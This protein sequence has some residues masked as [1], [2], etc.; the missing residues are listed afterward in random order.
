[1][2][3]SVDVLE[4]TRL[5]FS[6]LETLYFS[7]GVAITPR[8]RRTNSRVAI[9]KPKIKFKPNRFKFYVHDRDKSSVSLILYNY[10][11]DGSNYPI[12]ITTIP[13]R[14]IQQRVIVPVTLSMKPLIQVETGPIIKTELV[15][16]RDFTLDRSKL[17]IVDFEPGELSPHIVH[18]DDEETHEE[19]MYP[20]VGSFGQLTPP[21]YI[22]NKWMELFKNCENQELLRELFVDDFLRTKVMTSLREFYQSQ[23]WL[24]ISDAVKCDS[25]KHKTNEAC[26]CNSRAKSVEP[27]YISTNALEF[28]MPLL[29]SKSKKS[30]IKIK[31]HHQAFHLRRRSVDS[32]PFNPVPP[33]RDEEFPNPRRAR[34]EDVDDPIRVKKSTEDVNLPDIARVRHYVTQ[35]R[36]KNEETPKRVLNESPPKQIFARTLTVKHSEPVQ[37]KKPGDVEISKPMIRGQQ[38]QP[39]KK[40]SEAHEKQRA[41]LQKINVEPVRHE[42]PPGKMRRILPETNV[43]PTPQKALMRGLSSLSQK[44]PT[45][46]EVEVKPPAPMS[47]MA[48]R[49]K[50]QTNVQ[51]IVPVPPAETGV[52]PRRTRS[53]NVEN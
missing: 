47:P 24:C 7:L 32:N 2:E 8:G 38:M 36:P 16:T 30:N 28:E 17:Q 50:P 10:R 42:S 15:L 5:P 11:T 4:I 46:D 45:M 29:R 27:N 20:G 26:V 33:K 34:V 23:D 51:T 49:P 22:T 31:P 9:A 39:V 48:T 18:S 6:K 13:M 40:G 37:T 44:K 12:A 1:M 43:P 52:S 41:L 14:L 21:S 19:I 35:F 3:L 25:K 53:T